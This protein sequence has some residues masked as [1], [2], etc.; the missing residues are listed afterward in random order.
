MKKIC[1]LGAGTAGTILALEL[2][3][4]TK[5]E[6]ILLD[7]DSLNESFNYN[8]E[9]KK[10]FNNNYEKCKT[11]GY[12][13]GGSSNLWHG[14][15]TNLD[16]EDFAYINKISNKNIKKDLEKYYGK[17]VKY[18]GD[19]K[20]INE[21]KSTPSELNAY[22]DLSNFLEK[23]H[24]VQRSPTRFRQMLKKKIL[25]NNSNLKL[26]ENAVAIKLVKSNKSLIEKIIYHKN[27][28][29]KQVEADIFITSL[30][31][32]ESPRLLLQSL[33]NDTLSN[34][35][36]GKGLM[37][38]PIAFIG[39]IILT[40]YIF[41]KQIGVKNFLYNNSNRIGY[42]LKFNK[43]FS[44]LNHSF[45]IRPGISKN[46]KKLQSALKFLIYEKFS[47][48]NFFYILFNRNVF[49]LVFSLLSY[50]FG[51]GYFSKSFLVTMQLEQISNKYNKIE[52]SKDKDKYMRRI[53]L[54]Y[55][56]ISNELM[57][58]INKVQKFFFNIVKNNNK[59]KKFNI[60]N[61]SLIPGAHYSGT[62]RMGSNKS[63]SVID[64]NLRYHGIKNLYVC[65]SSIIPK[66]GNAN[67]V[68]TI[69]AFSIRLANY[70]KKTLKR[71]K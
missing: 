60:N 66:I 19:L 42:R 15:L 16:D 11:T 54:I 31:G 9:L 43:R 14:V 18:Y 24:I 6:I 59:F 50:K 7:C 34:R 39:E 17:L 21:K 28:K 70:L 63:N 3:N 8:F 20:Y 32:L 55:Q 46:I 38:H 33:E 45:F 25:N 68:Y 41:Y 65:D 64:A 36:I 53:P 71:I 1:I 29:F 27:G 40:K 12:G 35:L 47:F 48:K 23:K 62:C 52:L 26:I 69:S 2:S 30:G 51:F 56:K 57:Q 4:L 49:K 10:H 61:K 58:D 37:D 5:H 13:F 22:L 44:K 67:L